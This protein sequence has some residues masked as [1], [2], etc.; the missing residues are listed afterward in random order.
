[1]PEEHGV[2][3]YRFNDGKISPAGVFIGGRMHSTGAQLDGRHSHWYRLEWHKEQKKS[4]L[5]QVR[6]SF[7][8]PIC[9][10]GQSG[11][12]AIYCFCSRFPKG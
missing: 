7:L 1:V 5:V 3:D 2:E 12:S 9:P 6:K 4:C 10:G 11:F 8:A